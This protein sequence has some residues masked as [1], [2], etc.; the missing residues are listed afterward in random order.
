MSID[1]DTVLG[2]T[3][4]L[5]QATYGKQLKKNEEQ[6]LEG[7]WEGL[8]Y[9]EISQRVNCPSDKLK[10]N[11][12]APLFKK[13]G[14]LFGV[15]K[16]SKTSFAEEA[17]KLLYQEAESKVATTLAKDSIFSVLGG[18]PPTI[19]KFFG[20]KPEINLLSEA[21]KENKCV[22]IRGATGIGKTYLAAKLVDDCSINQQ[23]YQFNHCVWKSVS[24]SPSIGIL[25]KE[26]LR[27][28]GNTVHRRSDDIEFLIG[29]VISALNDQRILLT[30]DGFESLMTG[31]SPEQ[32]VNNK[33]YVTLLNRLIKEQHKSCVLLTSQEPIDLISYLE[34]SGYSSTT[35]HLEGLKQAAHELLESLGM[36]QKEYWH[37]LIFSCRG[38]PF[39]LSLMASNINEFFAGDIE[40][41][42]QLETTA[43]TD[44]FT[45]TIMSQLERSTD[46]E[47]EIL[48]HLCNRD[49]LTYE[50]LS[51]KMRK[52]STNDLMSTLKL[53][54][55]RSL[56]E[57]SDNPASYTILPTVKRAVETRQEHLASV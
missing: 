52:I 46:I 19:M 57:R 40:G 18:Q 29:E 47:L 36:K 10:S 55:T 39:L 28:L 27:H 6:V 50:N 22:T 9:E 3:N 42:L 17:K 51:K 34:D 1:F 41:Y 20:R 44:L 23:E 13:L 24:H 16:V 15:T 49:T 32:F 11:V 7:S 14:P 25:L 12:G 21:L 31:K 38:N 53:L 2:M 48:N 30:L 45:S 8:T 37:D 54:T 43:T 26:I 56:I 4:R 5:H 35:F 33:D